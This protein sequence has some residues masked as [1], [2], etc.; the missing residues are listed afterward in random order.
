MTKKMDI[1]GLYL[2]EGNSYLQ[3]SEQFSAAFEMTNSIDNLFITILVPQTVSMN[4][5]PLKTT[6]VA[7]PVELYGSQPQPEENIGS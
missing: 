3:F 2:T 5:S 6:N 7:S 4:G 1:R